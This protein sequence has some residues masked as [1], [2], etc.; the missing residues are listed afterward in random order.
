VLALV[1]LRVACMAEGVDREAGVSD[2]SLHLFS[3]LRAIY[4]RRWGGCVDGVDVVL[5]SL[6]PSAATDCD[7][8]KPI[9]QR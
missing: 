5:G 4:L 8:P 1:G 2:H 3:N 9:A 6:M 7:F